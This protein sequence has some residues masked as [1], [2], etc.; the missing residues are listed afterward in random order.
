VPSRSFGCIHSSHLLFSWCG[1][2]LQGG[3]L[4]VA[5]HPDQRRI[6]LAFSC[7]GIW[8]KS[9]LRFAWDANDQAAALHAVHGLFIN[10]HPTQRT[11]RTHMPPSCLAQSHT[12]LSS[13]GRIINRLIN[14]V[15]TKTSKPW[16]KNAH[17]CEPS[18]RVCGVLY[19]LGSSLG[20]ARYIPRA[21]RVCYKPRL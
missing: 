11:R 14:S 8:E 12:L 19:D 7:L 10:L 9:H 16:A 21:H 4:N 20:Q 6:Q 17:V 5:T 3:Q 2:S 18:T 13:R 1:T 15:H